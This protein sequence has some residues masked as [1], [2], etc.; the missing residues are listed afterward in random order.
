MTSPEFEDIIARKELIEEWKQ[1]AHSDRNVAWNIIQLKASLKLIKY[2]FGEDWYRQVLRR[3]NAKNGI[4]EVH[5]LHHSLWSGKPE[6]LVRVVHLGISLKVLQ[7]EKPANNL[8]AKIPDLRRADLSFE[9]TYFELKTAATYSS[10]GFNV[11]FLRER[12][13][14]KTPDLLVIGGSGRS[15]VECKKRDPQPCGEL[16]TMVNGALDRLREANSQFKAVGEAGIAWLEV[17]DGLNHN[18]PHFAEYVRYVLEE[19]SLLSRIQCVLITSIHILT[20]GNV[21]HHI[22][23]AKGVPNRHI[24]PTVPRDLWC[25]PLRIGRYFPA[26]L[27][28]L[29]GAPSLAIPNDLRSEHSA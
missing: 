1:I 12:K 7:F 23:A 14:K 13:G 5:P 3:I 28:E 6:D 21:T 4:E 20:S 8:S 15:Y 16:S 10:A 22:T 11:E 17:E 19:L 9:K 29:P 26:F 25:N 2:S 18:H 27:V 24:V